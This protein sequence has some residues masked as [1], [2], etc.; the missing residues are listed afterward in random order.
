MSLT[1]DLPIRSVGF[2]PTNA[3]HPPASQHGVFIP[4]APFGRCNAKRGR[5]SC[6]LRVDARTPR[7]HENANAAIGAYFL[8]G[9]Y[10]ANNAIRDSRMATFANKV[11]WV[12]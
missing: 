12:C 8:D 6:P 7:L 4:F 1:R 10:T 9:S 11:V 3:V 5:R 2:P